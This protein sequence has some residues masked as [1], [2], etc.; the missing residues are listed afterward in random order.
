[1]SKS[2]QITLTEDEKWLVNQL[3]SGSSIVDGYDTLY[4]ERFKANYKIGKRRFK[5]AFDSL[6]NKVK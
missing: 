2:K 6:K 5:S 1:M 3:I 4:A